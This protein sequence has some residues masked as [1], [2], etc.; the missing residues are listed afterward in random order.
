MDYNTLNNLY[1]NKTIFICGNGLGLLNITDQLKPQFEQ[2]ISIGVN[3]SF[4][5][6]KSPIYMTG[7]LCHALM[8]KHYRHRYKDT[9][10]FY[11]GPIE[12]HRNINLT[13]SFNIISGNVVAK[14]LP[15][16]LTNNSSISGAEN[17]TFAA[18]H[19]A[20]IMGASKIVYVGIDCKSLTHFY[21]IDFYQNKLIQYCEDLKQTYSTNQFATKD[22]NDFVDSN[23]TKRGYLLGG[24]RHTTGFLANYNHLLLTF[25]SYFT[26]LQEASVEVVITQPDGICIEAGATHTPLK[27]IINEI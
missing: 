1:K 10:N 8:Y 25:R 12:R 16:P 6:V 5:H 26:I 24:K 9:L 15:I 17:I 20:Y 11:Q 22:I 14:T 18:T 19:M 13:D 23:I 27:E 4:L 7:H 2:Q 21:D 3:S